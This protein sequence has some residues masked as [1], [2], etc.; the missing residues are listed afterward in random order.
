VQLPYQQKIT[1]DLNKSRANNVISSLEDTWN[2][3]ATWEKIINVTLPLEKKLEVLEKKIKTLKK[4]QE[5][6]EAYIFDSD[7]KVIFA[8]EVLAPTKGDFHD[9]NVLERLNKGETM[10]RE[11]FIDQSKQALSVYLPLKNDSNNLV[12]RLFFSL[13][14]LWEV[15]RQ[16]YQPAIIIG[17]LFIF[18]NII[19]GVFFSRL[20]IGPIKVFN[21]AAKVIAAGHLDSRV[22]IFTNDELEELANTFNFMAQELIKMKERAENANPLTK[23]PGN[24]VIMEEVE[25]RIKTNQKFTV[26]Y[27][28]LDNFKAF[29][30]KYGIHAG[31]E[32][33][34]MAAEIFKEAVK[35][36][37]STDDFVGHE[38]GDDFIILTTPGRAEAI[39][40]YITSEFDKR[41]RSLFSKEDLE[42][43][44]IVATGRDGV[45][46]QFPIMTISLAG[47]TNEYRPLQSYGEV[48]NI[49][50]E[51]KKKAKKE[52][53]S[54]FVLDKR[55]SSD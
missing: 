5:I 33:I 28:D 47:V 26:I 30:D 9:L 35:N 49:A 43:G 19:L 3:A 8:T 1:N 10:E 45:V 20:I 51:V 36:K 16:A 55:S 22:S 46:K 42:R 50:A 7:T 23:L 17:S 38:G 40:N 31:D 11:I 4:N 27:S 24:I 6:S 21:Q 2:F 34:K 15:S 44:Y 53:R 14:D 52:Q 37:G 12:L 54:C 25:K 18:V 13:K 32:A 48:T 41:V 29:N 39:A